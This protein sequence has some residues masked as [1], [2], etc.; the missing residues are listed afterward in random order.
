MIKEFKVYYGGAPATKE[1]L[2]AIEEIIVEQ[3]I[4]RVW[5]A[6]IK[7]P[8][9]I[10]ENGSWD[11]EDDPN[12]AE[13]ARVRVEARIGD[14]GFIP[15]IDGRITDQDPGLNANP[16]SSTLTLTVQDDTSLLHREASSESFSGDS[17]SDIARSIFEQA[18]LGG[19][20]DVEDTGAPTDPNTVTQRCGTP[21]QL[22]RSIMSRRPDFYAYVLPGAVPGTS[23]C[24]FKRLPLSPDPALPEL[25]LTGSERNISGF[26]IRRISNRQQ[27]PDGY[28]QYS[29]RACSGRD[30]PTDPDKSGR[31]SFSGR[32]RRRHTKAGF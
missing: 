1:Q 20:I 4:G 17:D 2:D 7:I 18:A 31:A 19:E 32:F 15:L 5:E 16:G 24:C 10:S 13:H 27:W 14:G 29:R 9:C 25:V 12:Y 6:R 30:N 26:N 8:I 21:M 22:L 23:N 28:C 3:E 11:G